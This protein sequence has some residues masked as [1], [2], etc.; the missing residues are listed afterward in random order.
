MPWDCWFAQ[1][2]QPSYLADWDPQ[3]AQEPPMCHLRNSS[4]NGH[5][6]NNN[7]YYKAFQ[8]IVSQVPNRCAYDS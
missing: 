6:N 8:L 7:N 1:G 3:P 4:D 5:K 2:W